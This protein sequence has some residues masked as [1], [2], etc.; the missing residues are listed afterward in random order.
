MYEV[1][2]NWTATWHK[3]GTK[4]YPSIQAKLISITHPRVVHS[5]TG[6]IVTNYKKGPLAAFWDGGTP[7]PHPFVYHVQF[8]SANTRKNLPHHAVTISFGFRKLTLK[9]RKK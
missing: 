5:R 8:P 9:R 6:P 4:L 2:P 7:I 1:I 3:S